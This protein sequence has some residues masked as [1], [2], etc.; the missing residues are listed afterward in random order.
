MRNR[1]IETEAESPLKSG[2][3]EQACARYGLGRCTMRNLAKEASAE[4]K[5]GKCYLINFSKVDM[6]LDSISK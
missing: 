5:V 3:I 1:I 2:R 4:I 6:Y